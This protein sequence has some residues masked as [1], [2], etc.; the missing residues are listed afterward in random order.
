MAVKVEKEIVGLDDDPL[1]YKNAI[2]YQI[3]VK[4]FCDSDGDGVGDFKGLTQKLGYLQDLGV[5]AIWLLPFYPSPFKDDGYDISDYRAIHPAYGTM[6]AFKAFLREAHRRGLRVI[7]ELVINHTSDQHRWFR[8]ARRAKPGSQWRDFYVWSDTPTRYK[9][10]RIIFQDFETSNWAWDPVAKAYYWHRFFSHQPDLNFDNP[11]VRREVFKVLEFWLDMGVDGLRLDAVPYLFEREGTNC[12]NLPES[13]D[14][15][16]KLRAHVDAKYEGRMLLAEANQWPEDAV[17]YFGEGDECHMSFHFPL[18]PRL[19]MALKMEDRY[20]IVDIL[21]Q[22]PSVPEVCQWAIFLRN[23]DELT[24]EMVTD[25]E[26]DYMYKTYAQD[27]QMRLNLGIRR[28]LAPLAGNHRRRIE[29][30][31]SLLFSMP[32]TPIVYYG[33]ELGM[34]DNIYLGDRNGVRTPMQWGPGKN[35]GFSSANPQRLYLPPIN[36]PEYHY[37]TYNVEAQQNNPHSLLWWMKRMIAVRKRLDA[38]GYGSLEFLSSDNNKVL[39]FIRTHEEQRILVIAN[40]SRFIQYVNL[41]LSEYKNLVPVEVFGRTSFPAIGQ[42]PYFLTLA[43]HCFFWFTLEPVKGENGSVEVE[44]PVTELPLIRVADRWESVF[45]GRGAGGLERIL[46]QHL[47][48]R[49]WFRGKARA[50]KSLAFTDMIPASFD[51]GKAVLALVQITYTDENDEMY[52]LPFTYTRGEE[53]AEA[54]EDS[55]RA[56]AARLKIKDKDEQGLLYDAF[57]DEGFSRGLLDMMARSR[58]MKGGA[59]TLQATATKNARQLIAREDVSLAPRMISAEQTNTSVAYGET[60][61]LKAFR[62][63]DPGVNPDLEIGS[64]LT[65]KKFQ[66][67]PKVCGRIVYRARKGEPATIAILHEYVPN[68]GDAWSYTLDFLRG[69]IEN[70]LTLE[71]EARDAPPPVVPLTGLEEEDIPRVVSEMVGPYW[72]SVRV[73]GKRT[74]ELHLALSSDED[75]PTFSPE[76]LSA[77][78][79]RAMYQSMRNLTVNTFQL[80]RKHMKRFPED[81]LPAAR[82][83]MGRQSEVLERFRIFKERRVSTTITRCHGDYHLGQVLHT[84]KDFVIIDFEGEPA[85]TLTERR[86]KR[87][88]LTDVAGMIRSFAYAGRSALMEHSDMRAEDAEI[89]EPWMEVWLSYVC[90]AFVKSYLDTAGAAPFVPEDPEDIDRLLKAFLLE[91]AVYELG[92]ELN[93]RPDWAA[94]PLQGI[95]DVLDES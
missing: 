92:Y 77:L 25:E 72:E 39:S 83:I 3:H 87:S 90:A 11:K 55:A 12:E 80:L 45:K 88:P 85:R 15:L 58:R 21:D 27:P 91:K 5:T 61:I 50:I 4:A 59:G 95:R 16:K 81:V 89:L 41:D 18:M 9:D 42:D 67:I 24:L 20:P 32:G 64:F 30:M 1:W 53:G 17:A 52:L 37:E 76:R 74:A 22:T 38:F 40:L 44:T 60:F 71:R 78:S 57:A 7:T 69:Y 47:K 28:R 33:D 10:T 13:H 54:A 84:G 43:P 19:F 36:D 63:P 86:R 26:R 23:H 46:P 68:E 82:E 8:R 65:R 93:N 73:L 31:N 49:R 34:G 6:G 56:A 35:A 70:V 79:Q 75:D 48:T 51:S 94:I 62:K 29:L 66:H 14:F 2:I